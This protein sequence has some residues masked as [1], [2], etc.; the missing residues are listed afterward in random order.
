[1]RSQNWLQ[2][3]A[4]AVLAAVGTAVSSGPVHAQSFFETLFGG[5]KSAASQPLA[6]GQNRLLPPG[7]GGAIVNSGA[8]VRPSTPPL[9]GIDRDDDSPAASSHNRGGSHRTVCVRMCDGF[10]WPVSFS[11]PRSKFYRDANACS[12]S[13]SSEA[14]LF[15][16]P[17]NG[18][19]IEDA[20]DL[21][22]RAYARLPTAFKYRKALVQGCTCKPEPWSDAELG[23]HRE[24][25]TNESVTR[26]GPVG[27]ANGDPNPVPAQSGSQQSVL[28][29]DTRTNS[30]EPASASEP[31]IV[32]AETKTPSN[33]TA[34]GATPRSI[35][36]N[37]ETPPKSI[38]R[39]RIPA[40]AAQPVGQASKGQGGFWSGGQSSNFSWPGDA[41]IRV[42]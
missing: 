20:I 15:H 4:L 37:G 13:C 16:F 9:R 31:E 17:S 40:N 3:A 23:R 27:V 30:A 28:V 21:T 38:V 26:P 5:P 14:K 10:Y 25:A 34:R 2:L 18:G 24:Y 1:M 35:P 6:S 39:P 36:A 8:A 29:S 11:A 22:G 41:P 19:Q 12:S 42:R 33:K 7:A 32:T